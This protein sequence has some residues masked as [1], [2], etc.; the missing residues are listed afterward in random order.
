MAPTRRLPTGCGRRHGGSNPRGR[1]FIHLTE[2]LPEIIRALPHGMGSI[3]VLPIAARAGRAPDRMI[4]R[5]RKNGRGAFRLHAPLVLHMGDTHVSD[6]GDDYAPPVAA[7]LRE[8]A[9][10]RF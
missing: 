5:A 2:K 1:R 10:L 9:A 8:G 6:T 4:L 3:E 7:A